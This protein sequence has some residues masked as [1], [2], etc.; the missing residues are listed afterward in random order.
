MGNVL[1]IHASCTDFLTIQIEFGTVATFV[2]HGSYLVPLA[3]NK[4]FIAFNAI[5]ET[6]G[7][8]K[9]KLQVTL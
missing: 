8:G 6:V 9:T 5:Y 3:A 2:Q 4:F 7:R 1:T